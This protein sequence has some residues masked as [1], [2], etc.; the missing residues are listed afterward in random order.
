MLEG[1][2]DT[3]AT[4]PRRAQVVQSTRISFMTNGLFGAEASLQIK[5]LLSTPT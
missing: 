5:Q 3:S 1:P 2:T 4:G